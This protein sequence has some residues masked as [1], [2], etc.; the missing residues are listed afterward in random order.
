MMGWDGF[1]GFGMGALSL[2]FMAGFWVLVVV[3]IILVVRAL[4]GPRHETGAPHHYAGQAQAPPVAPP[5]APSGTEQAP[6]APAR[7]EALRI[8]EERYARGDIGRD[9]FLERKADLL[10]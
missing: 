3:G 10:A 8:L 1:G 9:E 2:L 6:G 7:S 5:A 4:T